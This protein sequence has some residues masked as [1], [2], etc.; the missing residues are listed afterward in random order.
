KT[1]RINSYLYSLADPILEEGNTYAFRVT[2]RASRAAGSAP[3]NFR[4]NGHSE[5]CTFEYGRKK[6]KDNPQVHGLADVDRQ[7]PGVV[8]INPVDAL[9]PPPQ[10]DIPPP[11]DMEDSPDCIASC[12]A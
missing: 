8:K 1:V 9:T 5:V 7:G 12:E 10:A 6:R 11:P 2:A 4:N 3:L